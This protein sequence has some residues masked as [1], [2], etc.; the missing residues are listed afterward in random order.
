MSIACQLGFFA[1]F[2]EGHQDR[3]WSFARAEVEY[4]DYL[5]TKNVLKRLPNNISW[6]TLKVIRLVDGGV[7]QN[8]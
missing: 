1:V 5:D 2:N 3:S 7:L 8:G 4:F 6:G